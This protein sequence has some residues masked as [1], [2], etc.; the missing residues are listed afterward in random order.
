VGGAIFGEFFSH[1]ARNHFFEVEV[2]LL[3][4]V[5]C[6]GAI[7]SGFD[8]IVHLC[9]GVC[10]KRR[11]WINGALKIVP[12]EF[13]ILRPWYGEALTEGGERSQ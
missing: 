7:R 4:D 3:M 2:A 11:S 10:C 8:D 13:Y 9:V 1:T 12:G 5:K 6:G